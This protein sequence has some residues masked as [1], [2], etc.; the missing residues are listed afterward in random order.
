[1]SAPP[2]IN[3]V[4]G[5]PGQPLDPGTRAFMEPRFGHDFSQVRVHTD[6]LAVQSARAVNANAYT[7]GPKI[8]FGQNQYAPRTATGQQL[9]AHELTHV[10]Q[11]SPSHGASQSELAVGPAEGP[12]EREAVLSADQIASGRQSDT[13]SGT[14]GSVL[15]RQAGKVQSPTH[16]AA[17]AA[18]QATTLP[19]T[20]STG[21]YGLGIYE[22]ELSSFSGVGSPCLLTLSLRLHFDF[23]DAPPPAPVS[24]KKWSAAEQ[25]SWTN[26]FIRTVTSRWSYRYPLA[27]VD[28]KKCAAWQAANCDRALARVEVIPVI[29]D[30]HANVIVYHAGSSLRS[31]AGYGG[32]SLKQEDVEAHDTGNGVQV[33][34]EHEFGHLLGLDHSNPACQSTAAGPAKDVGQP[35]CYVGTPEQTADVMGSGSVVTPQDYAPFVE[36]LNH[37]SGCDWK[38]EGSAPKAPGEPFGHVGLVTGMLVGAAGGAV[39]GGLLGAAGGPLA[40]LGGGGAA[41]LGGVVGLAGGALVGAIADAIAS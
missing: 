1:M 28:R 13:F 23:R 11:Q 3:E 2:I 27:I 34:A 31:S 12:L 19:Q 40:A 18:E 38:T 29:G 7:V 37:Y 20:H 30:Q 10:V 5:S 21:N 33:T 41:L 26:A 4:L 6:E 32:G 9:L 14:T 36:E 25:N 15:Q 24:R 17:S 22:S 8:V 16:T 39:V 35:G